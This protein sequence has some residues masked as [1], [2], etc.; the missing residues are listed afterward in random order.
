[1]TLS[2]DRF[3]DEGI[4]DNE[5]LAVAIGNN[6]EYTRLDTWGAGDSTW[7]TETYT[8]T[9][10]SDAFTIQFTAR[11]SVAYNAN[12]QE[13]LAVDNVV[14]RVNGAADAPEPEPN[15]NLTIATNTSV[16]LSV[17]SGNATVLRAT[18]TNNGTE[19]AASATIR[20]Y[21]HEE[22]TT[23]PQSGRVEERR[24]A[25]GTIAAGADAPVTV[26]VT[27]PA[28]SANQ[29]YYYYFCT[30][31]TCASPIEVRVQAS[32]TSKYP[33]FSI[34]TMTATQTNNTITVR[35]TVQNS[36]ALPGNSQQIRVYRH[37]RTTT[38]PTA[39]AFV[40]NVAT[41]TVRA[42]ASV[43]RTVTDWVPTVTTA[44]TYYYYACVDATFREQNTDNN[45]A[46]TP[47]TI[48]VQPASQ[49]T[50][51]LTVTAITAA[52]TTPQTG[53]TITF[54]ATVRN[55]GTATAPSR[56]VRVYRH[57][58]TTTNP[59]TGGIRLV[60]KAVTGSLAPNATRTVTITNIAPQ[61]ARTY[62]YYACV[63]TAPNEQHTDNNCVQTPV[64]V[65]VKKKA[66]TP[67]MGG[68]RMVAYEYV[69]ESMRG[70]GTSSTFNSSGSGTITLGGLETD[71]GKRGFVVSGHVVDF[72]VGLKDLPSINPDLYVFQGRHDLNPFLGKVMRFSSVRKEGGEFFL[73]ADAAFV[74]YPSPP[75]AGC[76]LTW[77]SADETYCL[78]LTITEQVTTVSP[79]SV[80]G[81][82]RATHTVTGS[83]VPT[84]GLRVRS[85]GASSVKV[86]EGEVVSE[87]LLT[88]FSDPSGTRLGK[89]LYVV[90][91]LPS[92]GGDSGSPV[93]TIPD[94]DGNVRVVG[95]MVGS[96]S[97]VS[98][99]ASW[100]DVTGALDLKPVR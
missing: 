36:G 45:C 39:G 9:D 33:D 84:I 77:E 42:G 87:R 92:I 91:G 78:D 82:N 32:Q 53:D 60:N 21:R 31:N 93:Y 63:T 29:T 54:R 74:A 11:P 37:T 20:V 3:V 73:G 81:K 24:A 100:D 4:G 97:D 98:T 52:P 40:G 34:P 18:V 55:T 90:D 58:R 17:R 65:S 48:T 62:Y 28:V 5:Y 56:D 35:T 1:M 15:E 66:V 14:I 75:T 23:T 61:T 2:F 12:V 89:Y 38:N 51:D 25:T 7:Q 68:D 8:L 76:S 64:T 26:S 88:F 72:G 47:A 70:G 19:S 50:P 44:T 16:P 94:K 27:V 67:P 59:T 69:S 57:T 95:T 83:Q 46:Q 85:Y 79:L 22:P 13:I 49:E 6:G 99:F 86:R 80:R 96:D 30:D 71:T 10:L 43:T 41:G